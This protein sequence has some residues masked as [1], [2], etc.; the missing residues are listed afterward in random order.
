MEWIAFR[1]QECTAAVVL[2]LMRVYDSNRKRRTINVRRCNT[3]AIDFL[4]LLAVTAVVAAAAAA[5][6]VIVIIIVVT[7]GDNDVT[8]H[9]A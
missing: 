1:R 6:A 5:A 2:V 4:R 8:P 9:Q 3:I 7:T